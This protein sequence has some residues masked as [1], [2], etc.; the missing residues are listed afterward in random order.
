MLKDNQMVVNHFY[1][2]FGLKLQNKNYGMAL[3]VCNTILSKYKMEDI[4]EAIDLLY[5]NQPQGGVY[6]FAYLPYVID[7][8]IIDVYEKRE[9]KQQTNFEKLDVEKKEVKVKNT[10]A[11]K[12]LVKF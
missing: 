6:S 12:G 11:N 2:R 5:L 9:V 1:Q 4:I 3:G 8:L 10:F 7:K